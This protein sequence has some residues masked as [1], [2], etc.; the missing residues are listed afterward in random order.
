MGSLKFRFSTIILIA[1]KN[2]EIYYKQHEIFS[3]TLPEASNAVVE[4]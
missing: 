3:P 4:A 2:L 1:S